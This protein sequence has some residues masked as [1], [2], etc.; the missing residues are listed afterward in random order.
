MVAMVEERGR[1][2]EVYTLVS[3]QM[4][5]CTTCGLWLGGRSPT[6]CAVTRGSRVVRGLDMWGLSPDSTV[7]Q[8]GAR[9]L[10]PRRG[11]T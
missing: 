8:G 7:L 4:S 11:R 5:R 9:T 2:G 10:G 6:R 1:Q 3:V